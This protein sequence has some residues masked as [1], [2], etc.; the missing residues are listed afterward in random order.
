M[1][2]LPPRPGSPS[3]T[4][5]DPSPSRRPTRPIT[6]PPR[7]LVDRLDPPPRVGRAPPP[8]MDSYVAG[9][10]RDRRDSGYGRR[11]DFRER[12]RDRGWPER[13]E[14]SRERGPPPRRSP[15]AFER[16]RRPPPPPHF[17]AREHVRYRPDP[18]NDSADE[19]RGLLL[20]ASAALDLRPD[21]VP[22]RLADRCLLGA[23]LIQQNVS[24][25]GTTPYRTPLRRSPHK[26]PLRSPGQRIKGSEPPEP[27][28]I[29]EDEEPR[30]P[31]PRRAPTPLRPASRPRT[32]PLAIKTESPEPAVQPKIEEYIQPPKAEEPA[33]MHA[34]Y[35]EGPQPQPPPPPIIRAP[36]EEEKPAMP[37]TKVRK[38]SPSPPRHPRN[39]GGAPPVR[40]AMYQRRPSRSPPPPPHANTPRGPRGDRFRGRGA[41]RGLPS[42]AAS[43][44][45]AGPSSYAPPPTPTGPAAEA[46]PPRVPAAPPEPE[47]QLPPIP[48]WEGRDVERHELA[49]AQQA[50]RTHR[51]IMRAQYVQVEKA[52][53]R[54]LYEL[55]TATIELRAVEGRRRV[56]DTHLERARAGVL[57][58][59]YVAPP[60]DVA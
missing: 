38:R 50:S 58:I 21:D 46:P 31:P 44:S 28:L 18:L 47:V 33:P 3:R 17:D 54:A 8:H 49:L 41:R 25:S 51:A 40:G 43:F 52:T 30:V 35:K 42:Q 57:G 6:D 34:E 55:E 9:Y 5:D 29:I 14:R 16:D 56:A 13:R 48:A 32:L 39:R 2:S 10:D 1:A 4:R 11:P 37:D 59:E 15:E 7:R 24:N 22:L 27:G 45:H 20:L 19:L 12:D 53:R 36:T 26:S 60:S 23:L